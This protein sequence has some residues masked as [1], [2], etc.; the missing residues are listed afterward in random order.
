MTESVTPQIMTP[1]PV[2]V[3]DF[4]F[5]AMRKPVI[6]QRSAAFIDFFRDFQT[7]LKYLFQ[8]EAPVLA[9]PGT[10]TLAMEM[11]MHSLLP[12]GGLVAI[13][14]HGKFSERWVDFGK[15]MGLE[16]LPVQQTWGDAMTVD[17]NLDLLL[18]LPQL[19]ALVLTHCETS[20]GALTDLEE[21]AFACRQRRPD[22]LLLVDAMSTIGVLPYYHDAWQ[23]DATVC[24]SQKGL[25]NPSGTAFVALSERAIAQLAIPPADDAFHLG[26]YWKYLFQGSFPF[27]PPTQ[28]FYG[29]EKALVEIKSQG[30]PFRWNRSHQMSQRF[31]KGLRELGGSLFGKSNS[32]AVTAFSL[33]QG[34]QDELRDELLNMGFELAGG[35]GPLKGKIM[36]VG[37][38][39]WTEAE[40]VDQLLDAISNLK[41]E[42][43]WK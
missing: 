4:I 6:H 3:P 30:L 27:T 31:K 33:G 32:D 9:F 19:Q 37:H 41:L 20:T 38:F 24:S 35:Q 18:Q 26:Q 11:T 39:G 12:M 28:L 10:G 43:K 15:S 23:I 2:A 7:G 5:E 40:V 8:T 29:I 16:V 13:A 25:F 42:G 34:D 36:R 14:S 1:G 22:V 17:E 21:V